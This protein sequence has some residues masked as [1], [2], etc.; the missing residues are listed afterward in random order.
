M[1]VSDLVQE[2]LFITFL[3][4][5]R[6]LYFLE[7]DGYKS[8]WVMIH[9]NFHVS[10]LSTSKSEVIWF[11]LRQSRKSENVMKPKE[12]AMPHLMYLILG[13]Y[14]LILFCLL[15]TRTN[16]NEVGKNTKHVLWGQGRRG[17]HERTLWVLLFI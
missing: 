6:K 7:A 2:K 3:L 4:V 11:P 9:T 17:N 16:V 13:R 12:W 1:N 15:D 8:R 5:R 14:L 10:I